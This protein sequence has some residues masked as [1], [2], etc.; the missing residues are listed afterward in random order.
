MVLTVGR[1]RGKVTL[2]GQK[3][4]AIK[5]GGV[6]YLNEKSKSLLFPALAEKGVGKP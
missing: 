4:T 2:V 1:S 6:V 3:M 5:M